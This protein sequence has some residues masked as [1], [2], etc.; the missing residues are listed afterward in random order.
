[1][2]AAALVPDRPDL[3]VFA[4]DFEAFHARFADLFGRAEPREQ[5]AKYVRGL[6]GGVERR[7]SWQLAEAL[8]DAVPDRM[9]RLLNRATWG[10]VGARDRLQDFVAAQFGDADAIGI[11]DETGFLKKGERSVGVQRQ[12]TGTA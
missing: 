7:N 5:A 12:S 1:M 8:G 2:S 3:D 6:L 11:L 10:A 4:A 9:Q